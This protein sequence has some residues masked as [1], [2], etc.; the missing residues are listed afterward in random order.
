MNKK[1]LELTFGRIALAMLAILV[2]L[3]IFMIFSTTF[4]NGFMQIVGIREAVSEIDLPDLKLEKE[5]TVE[6]EPACKS[7]FDPLQ[8]AVDLSKL[9][10]LSD[11]QLYYAINGHESFLEM[12]KDDLEC[13]R[14]YI[15]QI[16]SNLAK[17][18]A[19]NTKR[20]PT[21]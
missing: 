19:E 1:G 10:E 17:L 3:G 9:A 14:A 7:F 6:K 16:E 13:P 15:T 12:N 4:R 11:G 21:A 2:F 8:S 18:R 20:N 5:P